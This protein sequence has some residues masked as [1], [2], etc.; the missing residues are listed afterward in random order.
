MR[1]RRRGGCVILGAGGHARVVIDGI[2]AGRSATLRSVLDPDPSRWG[3]R[4][5]GVPVLGGDDLLPAQ[6]RR[7]VDCFAVGV[8][9][10]GDGGARRRLF[11]RGLACRLRPLTVVHPSAVRSP[12]AE[13][14][15][16]SQLMAGSVVNAG[17][18]LGENVIVNTGAIVEHDC[19]VGDH[20]HVATGACLA[21]GVRVG[22]GALIGAGAVVLP[23][24]SVGKNAVIGAGAVVTRDVPDGAVAAGVPARPRRRRTTRRRTGR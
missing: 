3:D 8:G 16:G 5:L 22:A 24:L 15:A 12:W 2:R 19:R 23:G 9:S 14:G 13:I 11:A 7:G 10:V 20:A 6:R 21:G 1:K 17:A 4:V 18:V